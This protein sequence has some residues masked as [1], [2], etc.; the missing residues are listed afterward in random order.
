MYSASR[1]SGTS[2]SSARATDNASANWPCLASARARSTSA[3]MRDGDGTGCAAAMT[4]PRELLRTPP[5]GSTDKKKAGIAA[6][7]GFYGKPAS[8]TPRDAAHRTATV[9]GLARELLPREAVVERKA[10]GPRPVDGHR[11]VPLPSVRIQVGFLV[12][13]VHVVHRHRPGVPGHSNRRVVGRVAGII[14]GDRI[15]LQVLGQL[16]RARELVPGVQSGQLQERLVVAEHELVAG[17]S[18]GLER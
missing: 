15:A 10:D 17:A 1:F 14:V 12:G 3:S 5:G 4:G 7:L 8:G 16:V 18:V 6:R 11:L 9:R 2:A 13:Q